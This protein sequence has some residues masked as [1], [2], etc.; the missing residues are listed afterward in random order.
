MVKRTK[1]SDKERFIR[2]ARE[3]GVD[4]DAPEADFI[5]SLKRLLG[6]KPVTQAEV[7]KRVKRNKEG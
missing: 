7:K 4:E 5:E 3:L 2:V 6:A 1:E